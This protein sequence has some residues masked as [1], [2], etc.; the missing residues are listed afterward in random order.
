VGVGE[1]VYM[2]VGGKVGNSF[3]KKVW[4]ILGSV[5]FKLLE[6]NRTTSLCDAGKFFGLCSQ[7]RKE[8]PPMRPGTRA[9][10]NVEQNHHHHHQHDTN[11]V[12]HR[13]VGNNPESTR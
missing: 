4:V 12:P 5:I 2:Y 1:E 6:Q 9:Q 11:P 3:E 13:L 8:Y 7:I 10:F